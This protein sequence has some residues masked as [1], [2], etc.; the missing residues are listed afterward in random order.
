MPYVDFFLPGKEKYLFIENCLDANCSKNLTEC[1][2]Y[3]ECLIDYHPLCANNLQEYSNEC[4]M[5]KY[6]C[7]SNI[8]LTKLHDGPC[9]FHEQQ[10]QSEGNRR[11][12]Y[13]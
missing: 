4:E 3:I 5:S 6:A 1:N 10:Q 11:E 12:I 9:D 2:P 13:S 7:Q 8:R